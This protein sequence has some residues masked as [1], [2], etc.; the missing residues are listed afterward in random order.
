MTRIHGSD[1]VRVAYIYCDYK[2]QSIQTA[3]NLIAVLA[4]QLVG[5]SEKLPKQLENMYTELEKHRRRPSLPDLRQLLTTLC[6]ERARTYV[7]VDALDE[8]EAMHER[9]YLL[10]LLESLP[11]GSTRLFVTSR[12]YNE[13]IRHVF[14]NV[15]QIPIAAPESD[16]QQFVQEQMSDRGGFI[17]RTT[18]ILRDQITDTICF[19]ASGM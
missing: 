16:I 14:T 13:D 11:H 19:R 8:C 10:P 6:N 3:S 12:L 9:R 4:R 15:P 17:E 1:E 18:P 5:H 7:I 2:D